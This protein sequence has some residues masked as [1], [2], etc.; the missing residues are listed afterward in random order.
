MAVKQGNNSLDYCKK[1]IQ[2]TAMSSNLKIL[3]VIDLDPD[4]KEL[5]FLAKKKG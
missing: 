2:K 3:Q 5:H 4:K 1:I